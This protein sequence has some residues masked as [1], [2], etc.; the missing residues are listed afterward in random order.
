MGTNIGMAKQAWA[1]L[2][3]AAL[4]N[5]AGEPDEE[6]NRLF[7]SGYDRGKTFM[8]ADAAG[9]ID[10]QDNPEVPGVF[11]LAEFG[12]TSTYDSQLSDDFVLGRLCQMAM[13]QA[14][15]L[16]YDPKRNPAQDAQVATEIAKN[17]FTAKNCSLI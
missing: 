1:D 9:K 6:L 12:P 4:A 15:N 7:K 14:R 16:T 11:A 2:D 13:E 10:Q 3:C 8:K 5:Y 17:A